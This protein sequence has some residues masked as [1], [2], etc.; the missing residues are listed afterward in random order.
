MKKL[1]ILLL[2]SSIII[3]QNSFSAAVSGKTKGIMQTI[4]EPT[5][6]EIEKSSFEKLIAQVETIGKKYSSTPI[7]AVKETLPQIKEKISKYKTINK[8][9]NAG[10]NFGFNDLKTNVFTGE[11]SKQPIP[12]LPSTITYPNLKINDF[13][14]TQ[15]WSNMKILGY[16]LGV[17]VG[18]HFYHLSISVSRNNLLDHYSAYLKLLGK[19]NITGSLTSIKFPENIDVTL[20]ADK[21]NLE[22]LNS[23]LNKIGHNVFIRDVTTKFLLLSFALIK[24]YNQEFIKLHK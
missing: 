3:I 13:Y 7:V 11:F 1:T 10:F 18:T 15:N 12:Q 21:L 14:L 23:D 20:L 9:F 19:N 24:Q 17:A 6:P 22:L 5:I 2:I 4:P 16:L 8:D